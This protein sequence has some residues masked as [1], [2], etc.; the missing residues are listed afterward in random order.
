MKQFCFSIFIVVLLFSCSGDD[1]AAPIGESEL[2]ENPVEAPVEEEEDDNTE[3]VEDETPVAISDE[4]L[5]DFTQQET[6]KYFWDYAQTE[7]G[8]ARERF[9]PNEPSNDPNTVTIGG[10]GFGLMAIIVGIERGFITH[11]RLRPD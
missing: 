6:F 2:P 3:E 5:L 1:G 4:E 10:T 9:H 8:C 7:S 11:Q